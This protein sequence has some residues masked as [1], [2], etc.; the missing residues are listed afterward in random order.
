MI[1]PKRF[2]NC[3]APASPLGIQTPRTKQQRASVDSASI[4]HEN[5]AIACGVIARQSER[6]DRM[7]T[8]TLFEG[9]TNQHP[10]ATRTNRFSSLLKRLRTASGSKSAATQR[11]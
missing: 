1:T 11:R 7:T 9:L 4:R 5:R 10:P 2:K 8:G 6:N 3:G